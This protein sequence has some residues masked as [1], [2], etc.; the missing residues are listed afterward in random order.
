[1]NPSNGPAEVP[2]EKLR[3]LVAKNGDLLINDSDRCEGLLKDH[4][5]EYRR[6][7][8]ALVGALEERVPMELRSSWQNAMTPEA[9]RA[10][11]VQRLQDHRG[12]APDVADWAVDAWSYA[13]GVGLGRSSDRLASQVISGAA[14]GAGAGMGAGAAGTN[15]V[16]SQVLPRAH[17]AQA[18][19][20]LAQALPVQTPAGSGKA[21]K[22]AGVVAVLGIAAY[23]L[24][25][26]IHP[27]PEPIVVKKE[28]PQKV[29]PVTKQETPNPQDAP[30]PILKHVLAVGTPLAVRVTQALDSN[31]ATPGQYV[32]GIL[33]APVMLENA[34]IMP[35]GAKV[36]LQVNEVDAAGKLHGTPQINLSVYRL[37]A[38]GKTY[39]I[40]STH[41]TAKGSSRTVNAVKKGA[42]GG[43]VGCAVGTV[44]GAFTRHKKVGCGA[45]AAAGGATGVAVAAHDEIK[46]AVIGVGTV[47][48]F[49][50]TRPL[51][52]G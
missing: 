47:I 16:G 23:M 42:I 39:S 30:N 1:M 35:A 34:Q 41:F 31:T 33:T 45:G 11:L 15:W 32:N 5:G 7:I 2:R 43:G 14:M 4:C 37:D 26:V 29:Q 40:A 10:R 38:A 25:K 50:L 3:E 48:T 17:Q 13:L 49:S 36:L 52:I 6:E 8:S 22:I 46:P 44:I 18:S 12:L 28:E 24:P 27:T 19:A 20:Q 51:T 9:M 21:L